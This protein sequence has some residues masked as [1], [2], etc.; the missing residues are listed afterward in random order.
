MREHPGIEQWWIDQEQRGRFV[1]E[2][3][4]Q[5]LRE[6]MLAQGHLFDVRPDQGG[7]DHDVECGLLCGSAL[8]E[9]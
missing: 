7:D 9:C 1:T 6:A 5:M 8:P 2:Y 4:Y 3:S